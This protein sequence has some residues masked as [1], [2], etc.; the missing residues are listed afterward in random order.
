M[1]FSSEFDVSLHQSPSPDTVPP[2]SLIRSTYTAQWVPPE[3]V[4]KH[5]RAALLHGI[6][7]TPQQRPVIVFVPT[8]AYW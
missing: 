4:S 5:A 2:L 8:E 7:E 6:F 1:G 3:I